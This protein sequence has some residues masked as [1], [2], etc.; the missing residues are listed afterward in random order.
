M[1]PE[2]AQGIFVNFK[3]LYYY[4]GNKL[5]FAA[6]QIGQAFR[7][8]I[9]PRQGLLRVREFTLAEIE[10]FVDPED[11]S[12]PKFAKV[13]NLEFFMFPRDEQRSGQSAKRIRLGEAVSK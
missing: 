5:P 3:D 4:K 10:H 8:E 6:A 13:A 11:K 7:N 1:R 12:H 9:S 2:T